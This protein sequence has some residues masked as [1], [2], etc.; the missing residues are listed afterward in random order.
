M[1]LFLNLNTFSFGNTNHCF[2]KEFQLT[3]LSHY[4]N[5]FLDFKKKSQNKKKFINEML[6]LKIENSLY[7]L[8][9]FSHTLHDPLTKEEYQTW[10]DELE[11]IKKLLKKYEMN[12][13]NSG[14]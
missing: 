9:Q 8:Y 11:K 10:I 2:R 3:L 5:Q 14:P 12:I 6:S 1:V 13:K 7:S 4:E